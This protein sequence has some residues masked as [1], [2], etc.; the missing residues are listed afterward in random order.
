MSNQ[1]HTVSTDALDTLGTCPIPENSGRDAIHLAVEPVICGPL[2]LMAGTRIKLAEGTHIKGQAIPCKVTMDGDDAT[3]IVDPFIKGWVKP[4]QQ[5]WFVV[6]PRTITSLRHVWS[7]PA[8]PEDAVSVYVDTSESVS[9]ADMTRFLDEVTS[10]GSVP[11]PDP[12]QSM[13]VAWLKD[14]CANHLTE[15]YDYIMAGAKQHLETGDYLYGENDAGKF[16]HVDLD[17]YGF[18]EHYV[19][20]TKTE[21]PEQDRHSFFSCSC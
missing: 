6:L 15:R 8:F 5:F 14:Y 7:H 2:P 11:P 18:W 21:V 12:E 10:R 13:A 16:D 19:K 9:N 1:K 4:G 3:G 20:A 17:V